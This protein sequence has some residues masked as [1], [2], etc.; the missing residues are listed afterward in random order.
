MRSLINTKSWEKRKR[1]CA[2]WRQRCSMV[3]GTLGAPQ[4][5]RMSPANART[6]SVLGTSELLCRALNIPGLWWRTQAWRTKTT[7]LFIFLLYTHMY[8][9]MCVHTVN[10][11]F[12]W[13]LTVWKTKFSIITHTKWVLNVMLPETTIYSRSDYPFNMLPKSGQSKK[14]NC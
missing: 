11:F 8:I 10:C 7:R 9:H 1:G 6:G 14:V 4:T 3:T 5:R 2:M 12:V 13:N